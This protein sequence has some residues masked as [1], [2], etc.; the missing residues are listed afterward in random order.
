MFLFNQQAT[1]NPDYNSYPDTQ[2]IISLKKNNFFSHQEQL[3]CILSFKRQNQALVRRFKTKPVQYFLSHISIATELQ[4]ELK[5]QCYITHSFFLD[6]KRQSLNRWRYTGLVGNLSFDPEMLIIWVSTSRSS[7][8]F[9]S[10]RDW[11][12]R[13]KIYKERKYNAL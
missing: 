9:T 4:I 8:C 11:E 10:Q 2:I 13:G 1:Q 12:M 7:P 5:K 6:S 3:M